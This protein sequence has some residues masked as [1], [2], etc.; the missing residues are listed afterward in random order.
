MAGF[1]SRS[2]VGIP[3]DLVDDRARACYPTRMSVARWSRVLR[4][5]PLLVF[6]CSSHVEV[7][8]AGPAP[9]APDA[10]SNGDPLAYPKDA[11]AAG[12]RPALGDTPCV[13]VGPAMCAAGF[14]VDPSGFG[15]AAVIPQTT[16]TG[17]TRPQLGHT[18]CVPVGDCDGA[19]PPAGATLIQTTDSLADAIA[20]APG[21]AV[22]ALADGEHRASS[23]ATPKAITIVGRCPAKTT[24]TPD[25]LSKTGFQFTS[26]AVSI[27]GLTLLGF[28]AAVKGTLSAAVTIEDDVIEGSTYRGLL[29]DNGATL[30]VRRSVL[31][32]TITRK[33]TET[34]L[35]IAIGKATAVIEDTAFLDNVDGAFVA[36]DGL[37]I[38]TKATLSRV[39]V[40]NT[41]ARPDGLGGGAIRG[42]EGAKVDV[43]E[44]VVSGALGTAV[45]SYQQKGAATVTVTRSVITRTKESTATDSSGGVAS[46]LAAARGSILFAED[47]T[48]SDAKGISVDAS[49]EGSRLTCTRCAIL[50]TKQ[51]KGSFSVAAGGT[52]GGAL[53]LVDTAI[54]DFGGVGISGTEKG[55]VTATRTLVGAAG[56]E[57]FQGYPITV[58]AQAAGGAFVEL[59]DSAVIDG[60][61]RML[62]AGQL[63]SRMTLDGTFVAKR[64]TD[65][66][67]YGHGIVSTDFAHIEVNG[68][69]I[70]DLSGVG[71]FCAA[72]GG[73]VSGSRFVGNAIGVHA[74]EGSTLSESDVAPADASDTDLAVVT[75]TRFENNGARSGTGE[76]ALPKVSF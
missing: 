27:R 63:G 49:D 32:G 50:R 52:H 43:I 76:I 15:C 12:T 58:G 33:D 13:K 7:V 75:S 67:T 66:L 45:L 70:A 4:L 11:C 22:L 44:S 10:G 8:P 73:Y 39:V 68:S 21:G 64:G 26:S 35:A 57:I 30:T 65:P 18:E 56:N 41:L 17:A 23:I 60:G 3:H 38:P 59:H 14:V 54:F 37:S 61:E 16:C 53:T 71:F 31:R 9:D 28:E 55:H 34:T 42:F 48:V 69:V 46:S 47:T 5:L 29:V 1:R 20:A 6:A 72:G 74:Q 36:T 62:A 40:V 19:F 2:S 25:A 51:V 24:I